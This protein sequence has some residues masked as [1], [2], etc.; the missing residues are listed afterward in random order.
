MTLKATKFQP[1]NGILQPPLQIT[2][3]QDTGGNLVAG[4]APIYS[5]MVCVA[6]FDEFLRVYT[7]DG[8]LRRK[9][10][11]HEIEE[12]CGVVAVDGK[13]G[14][15]AVV[16][17]TRK[18]HFVTVS[19]DLEVQQH[20]TKDVPLE[21]HRISLSGQR[22][23]IVGRQRE[24]MFVVLPADG[25]EPLHTVR[26]DGIL[27]RG[28]YIPSIVQTNAG[29]VICDWDNNRVYFTD[30]G[31]HVVHLSTD[32][33]QPRCAAVTSWGHVL[34]T[35]RWNHKIKVFSGVG[36][37]LGRLQ[38]N[39]RQIEYP[40]YI[41]IDEAEAL[42]YVACGPSDAHELR[43]YKFTAGELPLLPSDTLSP[44]WL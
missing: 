15:L 2:N 13:Q 21:A 6:H 14:K 33:S 11:I 44:R 8:D 43:K 24:R 17:N 18:V 9:V 20:T 30:R 12:I 1:E 28:I 10:S 19:A 27:N 40:D 35:D 5:N 22:Q 32:C 31:G 4:I 41:H 16:D 3:L 37:Y 39:S 42:L 29:Y 23:L 38:D 34:I 25:D 26:A 36:D 7:G